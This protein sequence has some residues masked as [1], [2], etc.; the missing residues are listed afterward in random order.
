[1]VQS[2]KSKVFLKEKGLNFLYASYC[3]KKVYIIDTVLSQSWKI[4]S[5]PLR[6]WPRMG[7]HPKSTILI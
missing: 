4:V 5:E 1:M 2:L 3:Y 7:Q 6:T